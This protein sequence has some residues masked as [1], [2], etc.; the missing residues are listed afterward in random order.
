MKH[1]LSCDKFNRNCI[2]YNYYKI[3]FMIYCSTDLYLYIYT[4]MVRKSH[5]RVNNVQTACQ[6]KL[7]IVI[8]IYFILYILILYFCIKDLVKKINKTPYLSN[9]INT[10]TCRC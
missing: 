4:H 10:Y 9:V 2:F 6:N 1:I 8:I 7:N 5:H 3:I